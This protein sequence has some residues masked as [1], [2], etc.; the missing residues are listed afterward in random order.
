[1]EWGHTCFIDTLP[2]RH[3]APIFPTQQSPPTANLFSVSAPTLWRLKISPA[4][5]WSVE[6]KGHCLHCVCVSV[7]LLGHDGAGTFSGSCWTNFPWLPA[8]C[9]ITHNVCV[10][11]LDTH[12]QTHTPTWLYPG[13]NQEIELCGWPNKQTKEWDRASLCGQC[14]LLR[15]DNV[16]TTAS[17]V[18]L[19][20]KVTEVLWASKKLTD[21]VTQVCPCA[22]INCTIVTDIVTDGFP[23]KVCL[24]EG[25]RTNKQQLWH[26]AHGCQSAMLVK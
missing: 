11:I 25:R 21:V 6:H 7:K 19:D 16:T 9:V 24:C 2:P 4:G 20:L 22:V 10:L 14:V 12:T 3:F 18:G 8:E 13:N 23:R 26:L 5:V 17:A 1:M 15:E